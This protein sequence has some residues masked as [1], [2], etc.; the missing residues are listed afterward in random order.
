M[1]YY[2]YIELGTPQ[3]ADNFFKRTAKKTTTAVKQATG[4]TKDTVKQATDFATKNVKRGVDEYFG[5]WRKDKENCHYS[6][7]RANFWK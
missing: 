6:W 4:F 5:F 7:S 1:D 2:S 3:L